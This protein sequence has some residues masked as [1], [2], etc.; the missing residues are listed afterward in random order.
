MWLRH[1]RRVAKGGKAGRCEGRLGRACRFQVASDS[2]VPPPAFSAAGQRRHFG[3]GFS[4]T[5]TAQR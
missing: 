5:D 1:F 4:L 2:E 3:G